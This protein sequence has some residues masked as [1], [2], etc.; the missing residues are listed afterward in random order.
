MFA[1][2]LLGVIG[3]GQELLFRALFPLSEAPSFNRMRYQM[4]AETE[5]EAREQLRRGLAYVRLRFESAPDG[6][7][8]DHHLN[9]YGFRGPDFKIDPPAG[10]RRVLVIGDSVVEGQGAP[11]DGTMPVV[12]ERLLRESGEVVE[13]LNLGV[14]AADLPRLMLLARESIPLL[15]PTDVVLVIYAN[16]MPAIMYLTLFDQ[17]S[18]EHQRRE[19]P[20]WVPRVLELLARVTR[21]EP[22]ARRWPQPIMNY[23]T[24]VP[25]PQNPWTEHNGPPPAELDPD[26]YRSMVAGK[27]NPWLG[28]QAEYLPEMLSHDFTRGGSPGPYLERIARGCRGMGVNLLVVYVP[29]SGVVHTRYVPALVKL[30]MKR[31]IAEALSTDPIYRRQNAQLGLVCGRLEIPFVDTT[32]AL[33][34]QEAAGVPQFW[35]YDT[36]PR[37]DGY[38][39]IARAVY[40]AWRHTE[41]APG[42]VTEPVKAE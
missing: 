1:A 40:A 19:T 24:P 14:V 37:P 8:E 5:Q 33:A 7:R 34:T 6:Y 42:S 30:G 21:G 22:I 26:L 27:L 10:K 31:A 41:R 15:R 11:E 35:M 23:F 13:V 16:D 20:V 9:I 18:V 32:D 4:V 36:H 28:T 39:T 38:A 17:L 12:L 2:L 29:F 25:D 3:A